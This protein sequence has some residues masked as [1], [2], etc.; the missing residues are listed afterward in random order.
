LLWQLFV[1]VVAKSRHT[2]LNKSL[3]GK[4]AREVKIYT[5]PTCPYCKMAK[6]F[7]DD[8]GVKYQEFNVAEDKAARE[9][10]KNK[11][12][13]WTVPTICIDN[14]ILVGFDEAQLK[15]KLGL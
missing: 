4:M 9:E 12:N 15:E 1:L 8:K 11:C 7:L 13:S 2:A 5:T 10:M 3:G 14:E 6:K